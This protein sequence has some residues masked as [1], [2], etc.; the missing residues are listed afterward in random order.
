MRSFNALLTLSLSKGEARRAQRVSRS[1]G[2]AKATNAA[3]L[4]ERREEAVY[5]KDKP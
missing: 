3:S 1:R 2:P 5:A 4:G